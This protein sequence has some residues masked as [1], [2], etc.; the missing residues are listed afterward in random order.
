MSQ[1]GLTLYLDLVAGAVWCTFLVLFSFFVFEEQWLGIMIDFCRFDA[2]LQVQPYFGRRGVFSIL[3]PVL[4]SRPGESISGVLMAPIFIK[5]EAWRRSL[6]S[7][8]LLL[9]S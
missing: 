4:W 7:K 8:N 5:I 2:L 9:I 6:A 3:A 1:R